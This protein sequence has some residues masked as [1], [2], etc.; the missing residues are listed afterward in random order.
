M[1]ILCRLYGH[2]R[3]R[4]FAYAEATV[5]RSYCK[6]CGIP[7]VRTEQGE[8]VLSKRNW[9][10]ASAIADSILVERGNEQ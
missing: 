3:S 6:R 1:P 9:P 4:E 5:W 8:W 7:M 10:T 2:R